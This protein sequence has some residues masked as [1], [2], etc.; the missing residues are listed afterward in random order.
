MKRFLSLIIVLCIAL[1]CVALAE[2]ET[3]PQLSVQGTSVFRVTPDYATVVLGC[4][5]EKEDLVEAQRVNAETVERII[6][7]IRDQGV[8]DKD[9]VTPNFSIGSV[10][11]Y[12][13]SP[14]TQVGYRVENMLNIIVRDI[15]TVAAVM[16]A[17]LLAG[18][19][20]SYGITFGSTKQGEV[21]QEALKSAIAVAQGKAEVMAQAAGVELVQVLNIR[22]VTNIYSPSTMY[23]NVRMEFAVDAAKGLGDTIMS[24]ALE[25]TA[26]VELLYLIQ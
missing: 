3:I 14:A 18:A 1:P 4:Y 9:I 7:S 23:S 10:Y 11:D 15:E 16:N 20:Q 5:T 6:Q 22:E 24:G 12:N 17:A 2:G 19:N 21:Y 8:E 13:K 25:V 26:N